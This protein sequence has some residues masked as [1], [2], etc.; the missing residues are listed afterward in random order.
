MVR[1]ERLP[2]STWGIAPRVAG[3]T[4]AHVRFTDHPPNI[5]TLDRAAA[6]RTAQGPPIA[7]AIDVEVHESDPAVTSDSPT[8]C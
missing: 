3:D 6:G 8:P 2:I 5:G 4:V 1:T 7:A